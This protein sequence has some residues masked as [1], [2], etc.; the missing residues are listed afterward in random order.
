MAETEALPYDASTTLGDLEIEL[1]RLKA[2][3]IMGWSK[4]SRN[5]KW[6]GLRD[7]MS[8]L[9]VG[10]GPG[11]ITEQLLDMFPSSRV[12]CLDLDPVLL[13]RAKGYLGDKA[14]RVDFV[15]ASI[16]ES[17][18]P[19]NTFDFAYARLVFQHLPD[20]VGAA[21]EILRLLKPGGKLVILDVDDGLNMLIDPPDPPEVQA[22]VERDTE[23]HRS[24]GGDRLVGRKLWRIMSA[25]GFQD[26]DLELIIF[27]SDSVG[28]DLLLGGFNQEALQVQVEAGLLSQQDADTLWKAHTNFLNSEYPYMALV[29]FMACG[30]K[31]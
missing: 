20:R 29:A 2:Q 18:L 3:A 12:T 16:M 22:I 31:T 24:K 14:G 17:G 28:L 27:H 15:Q 23:E 11:F 10:S 4:E 21:R 26:L 8:V 1:Q 7:G 25:A 9:E 30:T 6:F 13:E 5:L 19:D